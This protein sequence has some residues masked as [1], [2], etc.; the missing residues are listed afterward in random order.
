[1]YQH[2]VHGMPKGLHGNNLETELSITLLDHLFFIESV[3]QVADLKPTL[4]RIDPKER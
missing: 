4:I 2:E 1:M 3:K